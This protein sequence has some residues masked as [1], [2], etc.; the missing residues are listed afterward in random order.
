MIKRLSLA[1]GTISLSMC[2]AAHAVI[3]VNPLLVF[4]SGKSTVQDVSVKNTGNSVAYVEVAPKSVQNAG[5]P[6][7]AINFYKRG[8]DASS[9]GIMASP[10]KMAIPAGS[11]R[12]IRIVA[13]KTNPAEDAVYYLRFSEVPTLLDNPDKGDKGTNINMSN[14]ISY[15]VQA[16]ILPANPMP[17]VSLT[18]NGNNITAKNTG[19]SYA[20]LRNGQICNAQGS[21]CKALP[22][23]LTYKVLYVGNTWTFN[24]PSAGVVKFDVVYAQ[25]KKSTL[26]SN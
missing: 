16:V 1:V 6:N 11:S 22:A 20:S 26:K 12:K 21:D 17:N 9:F 15:R 4:F 5:A 13:L 10:L 8:S 7:E 23:R 24:V 14:Q 18:R 25:N 19:N 2:M 3:E